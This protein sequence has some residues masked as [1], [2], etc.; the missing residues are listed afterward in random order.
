MGNLSAFYRKVAENEGV[1]IMIKID[2]EKCVGCNAC[3]RAC[4]VNEANVAETVDARNIIS[5]NDKNCIHCGECVKECPHDARMFEDDT[6]MFF[7]DL[8]S[9]KIAVLVTCD[10]SG[11]SQG[12]GG[13]A[14]MDQKAAECCGYL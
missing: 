7:R 14:G 13:F 9:K 2:A 5:I 1:F 4:P 8:Q 11:I 10:Q 3:I 6:E 12:M